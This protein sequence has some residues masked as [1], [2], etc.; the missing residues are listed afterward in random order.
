MLIFSVWLWLIVGF[1]D[2]GLWVYVAKIIHKKCSFIQKLRPDQSQK[3]MQNL[4]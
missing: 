3:E 4:C 2:L 1:S